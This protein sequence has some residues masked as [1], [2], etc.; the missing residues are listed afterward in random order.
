MRLFGYKALSSQRLNDREEAEHNMQRIEEYIRDRPALLRFLKHTPVFERSQLEAIMNLTR[1]ISGA[2][3]NQ[4]WDMKA[5]SMSGSH[6]TLVPEVVQ[7]VREMEE[8]R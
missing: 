2:M 1:D 3:I 4:L 6:L 5:V 7:R 8:S